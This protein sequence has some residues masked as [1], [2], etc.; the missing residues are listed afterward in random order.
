MHTHTPA[1]LERSV[2]HLQQATLA[3]A[4]H[5]HNG[6][7]NDHVREAIEKPSRASGLQAQGKAI[8]HAFHEPGA[9]GLFLLVHD[10]FNKCFY[11]HLGDELG[12]RLCGDLLCQ[13]R[14]V[15]LINHFVE[16]GILE[17]GA[18]C[19][20]RQDTLQWCGLRGNGAVN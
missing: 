5:I 3:Q 20:Y 8:E 16:N 15:Q 17:R 10:G 12:G 1:L 9:Q 11:T 7:L 13:T 2:S 19:R 18:G 6:G 14:H 4:P